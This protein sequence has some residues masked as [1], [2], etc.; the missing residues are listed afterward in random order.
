MASTP[1]SE[2]SHDQEHDPDS[3]DETAAAHP[4]EDSTSKPNN[5]KD[6][7]CQYCRQPFTSSSLG[8]HLDQFISK[9]KPDGIHD[10]DEI[11][12]LRG[13]ITRRIARSGRRD[14]DKS[15]D[16]EEKDLSAQASPAPTLTRS[17][18]PA[19]VLPSPVQHAPDL[20]QY[21]PGGGRMYMNR[22]NWHSTG[23]ITDPATLDSPTTNA[24][25]P[26]PI[27]ASPSG[28]KRSF[29][30]YAQDLHHQS[31]TT[32]G[33][34]AADTSRAL[35]LALREV[36]DS[37]RIATKHSTP[38]PAP[39]NFDVQAQTFP[40]LCLKLLPAPATLF[41]PAPFST[42]QS[43][44]I[45]IPGP[46]QLAALRQKV[47]STIDY[48]KWQ[49]LRLAQSTTSNLGEE[50]DF[51]SR[52]AN[53]WMENTLSHLDAAFQNWMV[54]PIETRNLLWQVEMLRAYN[55]EQVKVQEVEA[56][57]E[58]LKQEADQLAQQVEYLSRCQWPREMAQWPPE[59]R[60]FDENMREEL[61]LVSSDSNKS[62][63]K[64]IGLTQFDASLN[65][66][67]LKTKPGEKW[68]YDKLVN[69]WKLHVKEDRLRRMPQPQATVDSHT[70]NGVSPTV[71]H[72]PEVANG[73]NGVS[74]GQPALTSTMDDR[75]R[76]SRA[77]PNI[78][79]VSDY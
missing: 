43:A 78:S 46:E 15:H 52:S 8:R 73:V 12:R 25:P 47:T 74:N 1:K 9:K 68:D 17:A 3:A 21:P 76:S 27:V 45:Q 4:A 75:R 67:P 38:K 51:L 59:R 54:H 22:L 57:Y 70:P 26:T 42:P 69:K 66:E 33:P 53:E 20:T 13:G 35:E 62:L 28:T 71:V 48:W 7:E 65:L 11:R 34:N 30:V 6:K 29:S 60:T 2:V 56:R 50:A 63:T 23:V 19:V 14:K 77:R 39:F 61:R 10:V 49:A 55:A 32:S 36:L 41:Q 72:A 37:L 18:P 64:G 24:A 16:Q 40:S 44:P 79:I 58:R 5:S 31:N